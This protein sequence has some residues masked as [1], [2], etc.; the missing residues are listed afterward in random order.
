MIPSFNPSGVLPPYTGISPVLPSGL[1]PYD[2]SMKELA[3]TLGTSADRAKILRGFI[4]LR[5]NLLALGIDDGYQW[6]AG[7]FCEDIEKLEVRS[8]GDIDVVTFFARPTSAN[9]TNDWAAFVTSNSSMFDPVHNKA[10]FQCDA[11]FVDGNTN[12]Q[13]VIKQVTYWYG[14]FSHKRSSHMWKGMLRIPL[15]S[16]DTE[17]LN[18]L[19]RVWP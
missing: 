9:A 4:A 10:M 11:Y 16:N 14:L 3:E 8:P 5:A 7:S 15:I 12:L 2:A 6:C 13:A 17:A 1:S 18:Y 19:N